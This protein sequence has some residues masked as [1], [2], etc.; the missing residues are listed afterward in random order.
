MLCVSKHE[1]IAVFVKFRNFANFHAFFEA[2]DLSVELLHLRR[3]CA[4]AKMLSI[5]SY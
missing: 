4:A 1:K 3:V 5:H 2:E